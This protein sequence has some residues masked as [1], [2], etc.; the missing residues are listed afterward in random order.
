MARTTLAAPAPADTPAAIAARHGL[1]ISGVTPPLPAY[2][3]LLWQYRHFITA[4]GSAKNAAALT[5]ARLGQLW[6][7]LTPLTNALIYYLIFGLIL[8]TRHGIDN[9]TAYLCTGIFLFGYTQQ[10]AQAAV[11]TI[12]DHLGLIR[13]LQFPRA[14]LPVATTVSQLQQMLASTAVL[15]AIVTVTGEPVTLHWLLLAPVLILQS[16]FNAGLALAV[17]RLGA[18]IPDLRQLLPFVMRTWMYA[19]GVFYSLTLL[20]KHLPATVIAILQANPM[21][22][23]IELARAAL[24]HEPP[25]PGLP[26]WLLW[27]LATGWALTAGTGG[28]LYFWR[29]EQEYARG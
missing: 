23:Y 7:V 14:C 5:S 29:G 19:S 3:R 15:L 4:F 28:Y 27:A 10:V 16:V 8:D 17:A 12:P 18:K 26:G 9:F 20:G 11:R 25:P 24:L 13:A 1:R 6:Q 21:L 22:I 2:T